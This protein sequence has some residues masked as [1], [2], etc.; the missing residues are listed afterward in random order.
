MA[1]RDSPAR[2]KVKVIDPPTPPRA[3]LTYI[4]L[5]LAAV[6]VILLIVIATRP[7][8]YRIARSTAVAAPPGAV[9]DLIEDFHQWKRWSPWDKLDPTQ[10]VTIG[11]APRGVGATYHW[12]GTK[13]GEGR[14]EIVESH[15][16][17]L[18]GVQLEFVKPFAS[19][20]RC[21]FNIHPA[22]SGSTV[23]W[24]MMGH[25]NFMAKAFGMFVN[26]DRMLGRDFE[27]GLAELKAQ[28]ESSAGTPGGTPATSTES[29][30]RA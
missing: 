30:T 15:P 9:M 2:G 5:G 4:L 12:V 6:V 7:A 26:M 16:N 13:N 11:G 27:R 24:S 29:R 3:M 1:L 23:E 19:R 28:A 22:G 17:A 18:V 14:M 20:S 8:S 10:V 21:D 25:N